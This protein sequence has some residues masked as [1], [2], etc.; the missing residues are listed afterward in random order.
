MRLTALMKSLVPMAAVA[1]LALSLGSGGPAS[2]QLA[3]NSK[4]PVDVTADELEVI[5]ASCQ[6]TWKGN[7]EALQDNSRLRADVLRIFTKP[8]AKGNS[9]KPGSPA[10]GC[11]DMERLEAEGSVYYV[12]PD[13]KVRANNAVYVAGSTT[14][15]MTG[16]VVA[17]RGRDVLRGDKMVFNTDTGAG[18]VIGTSK[19]RGAKDRPRGVFY[20][21]QSDSTSDKPK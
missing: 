17:I 6:A 7:A 21:S 1:V 8:G 20:P 14:I 10:S 18:Q 15:T 12:T 2:A 11:G 16:D 13:Q 3:T 9:G 19:G 4:A 5:N